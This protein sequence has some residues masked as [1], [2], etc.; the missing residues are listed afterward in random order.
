MQIFD[1][2]ATLT[3]VTVE[4]IARSYE[5]FIFKNHKIRQVV[6]S[7]GGTKN[8]F[9]MGRLKRRLPMIDF[10]I[11]DDS[12]MPSRFKECALFAYLAFLRVNK[13]EVNLKNIT[14]S[15]YKVILGKISS[16]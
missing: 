6:L 12:G 5:Q 13:V 9:L 16:K 4:T 7:G 11:S 14:G 2:L 15:K 1:I 3:E 8:K 10:L